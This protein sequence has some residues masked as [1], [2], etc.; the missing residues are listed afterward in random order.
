MRRIG[1]KH[2]KRLLAVFIAGLVFSLELITVF[3][4]SKEYIS[5]EVLTWESAGKP[6]LKKENVIEITNVVSAGAK[7]IEQTLEHNEPYFMYFLVDGSTVLTSL[8]NTH[9]FYVQKLEHKGGKYHVV[10]EYE[11]DQ[12]HYRTDEDGYS[13][14]A[15]GSYIKINEPGE[16]GVYLYYSGAEEKGYVAY[17]KVVP[18]GTA[19]PIQPVVKKAASSDIVIDVN[20]KTGVPSAYNIDG[21]NYIKLRDLAYLLRFERSEKRFSVDWDDSRKAIILTSDADYIPNNSE[22]IVLKDSHTADATEYTSLIYKDGQIVHFDA[23][24]I[25]GYN[26]FKIRDIAKAF[27][28]GVTWDAKTRTIKLDLSKDYEE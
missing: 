3:A 22:M 27:N 4:A 13:Y 2:G 18:K 14:Y 23:Y 12:E 28:F 26:Y 19:K 10:K 1:M 8:G 11:Q 5:V 20:G 6:V 16:Y 24:T 7:P 17:I 21:Y 15:K 9:L 25:N